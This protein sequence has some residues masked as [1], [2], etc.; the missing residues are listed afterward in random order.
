MNVKE[1]K[2]LLIT[3]FAASIRGDFGAVKKVL[4]TFEEEKRKRAK[5][6]PLQTAGRTSSDSVTSVPAQS[7]TPTGIVQRE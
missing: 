1:A 3:A 4:A 6:K 2:A 5:S 7:V